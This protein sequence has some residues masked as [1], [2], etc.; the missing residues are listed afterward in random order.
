[1]KHDRHGDFRRFVSQNSAA[2]AAASLKQ[3]L[4]RRSS[5]AP[6]AKFRGICRGLIEASALELD[7]LDR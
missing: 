6:D 1:L 7:V 3:G 2:S 4:A 5:Q